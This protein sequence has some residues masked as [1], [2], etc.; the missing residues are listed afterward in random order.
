MTDSD[1]PV[2]PPRNIP[3]YEFAGEGLSFV[4]AHCDQGSVADRGEAVSADIAVNGLGEDHLLPPHALLAETFSPNL[5][6]AE[7]VSDLD[8]FGVAANPAYMGPAYGEV[9]KRSVLERREIRERLHRLRGNRKRYLSALVEI[10]TNLYRLPSNSILPKNPKLEKGLKYG[11]TSNGIVLAPNTVA[12]LGDVC[13]WRSAAC[14]ANCLNLSG[15]AEIDELWGR[16]K[17]F[18]AR[19]RRTAM[20]FHQFDAFAGRVSMIIKER[21][22]KHPQYAVRANVLSDIPWEHRPFYWPWSE[23][24]ETLMSAF[25]HL[26]FYDYTKNCARYLSWLR[27]ELPPNYHLTFSLSEVNAL[28]AFYA[29][30]Q[31]GS[32]AVVFDARP[33]RIGGHYHVLYP[34]DPIPERF[35]GYPVVDGDKSDLRF[36]DRER[37]GLPG[38]Q[39]FVVGLRLKGNKHRRLHNADP[40]STAGFIFDAKAAY[41]K[42][43]MI[44]LIMDAE[45]RRSMASKS[46]GRRELPGARKGFFTGIQ[47]DVAEE[48]RRYFG[49]KRED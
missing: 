31:G 48:C 6:E 3:G 9:V 27:N 42:Q 49:L 39:G 34:A 44:D 23:G 10:S 18:D 14:T 46:R 41:P 32:V 1:R 29:L 33:E 40:S 11:W 15:Q 16:K 7:S 17:V 2:I 28:F 43:A 36:E 38:K 21:S 25:P 19:R 5:L 20:Y 22:E 26:I 13:P 24:R 4:S 12:G 37:F 30:A 8:D 45:R 47:P 35:C